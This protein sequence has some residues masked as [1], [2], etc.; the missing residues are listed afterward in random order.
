V[1]GSRRPKADRDE[2]FAND[3][4]PTSAAKCKLTLVYPETVVAGYQATAYQE[5]L[6]A[7]AFFSASRKA[8]NA[9]SRIMEGRYINP[10][11]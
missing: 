3:C 11:T 2:D 9:C 8:L 6:A 7:M 1:K 10:A 4:S 5:A